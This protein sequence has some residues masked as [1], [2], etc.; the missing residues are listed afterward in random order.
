[1]KKHLITACL[2]TVVTAVLLGIVYPL[3]VT[4]S[5]SLPSTTRPTVN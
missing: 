3:L 1:M 5:R 2:Y 4:G